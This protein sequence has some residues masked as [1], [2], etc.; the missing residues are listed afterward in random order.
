MLLSA[1]LRSASIVVIGAFVSFCAVKSLSP[2]GHSCSAAWQAPTIVADR[3]DTVVWS[4]P[5]ADASIQF[6]H[7]LPLV[8][9]TPF[10]WRMH[11]TNAPETV[12]LREVFILPEAPKTW[13][14]GPE[15]TLSTDSRVAITE[16]VVQLQDGW[17]GHVW[18]VSE[19]DPAGPYEM[20]VFI[21][22]QL[23]QVFRYNAHNVQPE[24]IDVDILDDTI[25]FDD[26]EGTAHKA[27]GCKH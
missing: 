19:G 3:A 22:D 25:V 12:R 13:G 14:I 18:S 23:V 5:D 7:D 10:G 11:L 17:I 21:N 15:T 24:V 16:E 26:E 8:E 27:R 9:D 1:T 2:C 4:G 6:T 20:H